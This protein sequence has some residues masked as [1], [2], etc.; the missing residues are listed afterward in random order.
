M[1][2]CHDSLEKQLL[3]NWHPESLAANSWSIFSTTVGLAWS[4]VTPQ[5]LQGTFCKLCRSMITEAT[6]LRLSFI[7]QRRP[8]PF[9]SIPWIHT[10]SKNTSDIQVILYTYFPRVKLHSSTNRTSLFSIVFPN[11]QSTSTLEVHQAQ[12]APPRP[13]HPVH[14][15]WRLLHRPPRRL[16]L[17]R[18]CCHRDRH[19][20]SSQSRLSWWREVS[21]WQ[22]HSHFVSCLAVAMFLI[23][24][25]F[26]VSI[27]QYALLT[28]TIE[29][30]R[31]HQ[32]FLTTPYLLNTK[33]SRAR[34]P[35][36]WWNGHIEGN[37]YF[38]KSL[39]SKSSPSDSS[40]SGSAPPLSHCHLSLRSVG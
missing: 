14:R 5:P 7:P 2:Y 29:R 32:D 11:N 36:P 1:I 37:T 6:M 4:I 12:Q 35:R 23:W 19:K 40:F 10:K 22:N 34:P 27:Q 28:V 26:E 3:Q 20:A 39:S 17:G 15:E 25:G 21:S 38:I 33:R 30:I 13:A 24:T 18:G 16:P 9:N 8:S 31:I